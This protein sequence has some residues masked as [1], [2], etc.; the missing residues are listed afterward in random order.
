MSNF[1][2]LRAEWPALFAEAARAERNGVADPRT[3]CFYA[4]RCLELAINWL[5]DADAT[6]VQPYRDELAAKLFEPSLRALVGNDIQTKM[7]LIRR[8]GNS[9]VH[10]T[11]PVT[12]TESMPVLGQ[13][14][15][16]LYWLA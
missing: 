15:Q 6:L 1:A 8:Q 3:A 5:Y 7:D 12:T 11:R 4:R 10:M 9:A 16:V 2:F 13:L 14:F